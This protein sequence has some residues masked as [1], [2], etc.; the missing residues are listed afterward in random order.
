MNNIKTIPMNTEEIQELFLKQDE[1]YDIDLQNS[2][3]QGEAFI[4]YIANMQMNCLLPLEV[5]VDSEKKLEVLKY[6]FTFRQTV[7]CQTL[8]NA[9]A[10]VLLYSRNIPFDFK[11][12]WL[13]EK[14]IQSFIPENMETLQKASLFLESALIFIPSFNTDFKSLVLEPAIEAGEVKEIN[15]I[16]FIGVNTL[17]LFTVPSFLEIF[18]GNP[19]EDNLPKFYFREQVEKL[20]YNSKPLFELIKDQQGDSFLMSLCHVTFSMHKEEREIFDK[21]ITENNDSSI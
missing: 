1:L 14:E 10:F 8:I 13:T 2:K 7:K 21:H 20:Y 12:C 6:F 15:D 4:T 16:D 18:L 9:A 11:L 17:G 3:L 19:I 5:A